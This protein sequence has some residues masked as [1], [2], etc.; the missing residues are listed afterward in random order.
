MPSW[1]VGGG[2]LAAGRIWRREAVVEWMETHPMHVGGGQIL[3]SFCGKN[4]SAVVKVVADPDLC[5]DAGA[6][7]GKVVICN[8][9]AAL[10]ATII[11]GDPT[12]ASA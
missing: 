2:E 4:E 7:S 8:E 1:E 11:A 3:C 6:T 10:A 5:D 12:T 9:C